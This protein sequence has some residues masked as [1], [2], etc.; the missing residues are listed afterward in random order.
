MC[1]GAI[2][3]EDPGDGIVDSEDRL[4]IWMRSR[5]ERCSVK[6]SYGQEL[7]LNHGDGDKIR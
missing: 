4:Q 1:A 5:V 3:I 2:G 6:P 7:N